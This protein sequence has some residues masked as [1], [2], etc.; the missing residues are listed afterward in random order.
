MDLTEA[1]NIKKNYT[2]QVLI[3]RTQVTMMVGSL[4]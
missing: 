1:E 2:K 3:K 4:I